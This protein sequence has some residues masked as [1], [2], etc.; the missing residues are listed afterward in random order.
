MSV[1]AVNLLDGLPNRASAGQQEL[2]D[3]ERDISILVVRRARDLLAGDPLVVAPERTAPINNASG[4]SGAATVADRSTLVSITR[5]VKAS[6]REPHAQ[7]AHQA[8][9]LRLR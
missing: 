8:R 6:C 1:A 3:V 5:R 4:V 2:F 7:R 9:S